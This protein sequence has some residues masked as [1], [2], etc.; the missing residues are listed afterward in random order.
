MTS[1]NY[2]SVD[3]APVKI[4]T[5][6]LAAIGISSWS[7]FAALLAALYSLILIGEWVWKKLLR[8]CFERRG[9]VKRRMRRQTDKLANIGE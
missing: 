4:A 9:W 7:D 2:T 1:P 8:P 6:W 5:A 3:Y